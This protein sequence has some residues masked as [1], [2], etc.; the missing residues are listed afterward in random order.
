MLS[1]GIATSGLRD[2]IEDLLSEFCNVGFPVSD[3]DN[4]WSC[5]NLVKWPS[6]ATGECSVE[7]FWV[8]VFKYKDSSNNQSFSEL[9]SFAL[10]MLSLPLSNADVERVFSQQN[11]LKTKLRNRLKVGTLECLLNI[12]YGLLLS[13]QTTVDF[14]PTGAMF[15]RFNNSM[16]NNDNECV[17]E[18]CYSD[19]D[20]DDY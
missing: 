1:P 4:Q 12:R 6:L 2:R 16:Y 11:I 17:E 3:I 18:L 13:G 15:D 7:D 5:L 8:D 20:L 9:A 10:A 14:V 19:D